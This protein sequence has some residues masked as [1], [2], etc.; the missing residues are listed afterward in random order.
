MSSYA[1]NVHHLQSAVQNI[2]QHVKTLHIVIR[3]RKDFLWQILMAG[4]IGEFAIIKMHKLIEID[5]FITLQNVKKGF[6]WMLFWNS[7][8][9]V[10]FLTARLAIKKLWTVSNV[11]KGTIFQEIFVSLIK[12]NHSYKNS[13]TH[14]NPKPNSYKLIGTRRNVCTD[15]PFR[16]DNGI[17]HR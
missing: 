7:A 13:P 11:K 16:D 15:D 6:I 17:F 1:I 9:S 14:S 4:M 3:V 2:V 10:S 5:N 12:V 8:K